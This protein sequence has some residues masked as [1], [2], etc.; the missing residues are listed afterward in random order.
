MSQPDTADKILTA[1]EQLFAEGGFS[2]VSVQDIATRAEVNKALIFYH[3][4]NKGTLFEKV[5]DRYY[6][7]HTA[8]LTE[9]MVC[10]ADTP[11]GQRLHQLVDTYLDFIET[12]SHMVR[13]VQSEIAAGG[14]H[15]PRIQQGVTQLHDTVKALLAGVADETGPL[16]A[17]QFFVTF[18]GLVNTYF[19]MAP[20]LGGVWDGDP[21]HVAAKRERREHVHFVVDALLQQLG[22]A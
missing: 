19:L 9:G 18:A 15:L 2:G 21:M 3:H 7:A 22:L 1:A 6:A 17:R 4:G 5:L 8:A 10:E 20:A 13:L 12:H 11:V 16:A 14:E